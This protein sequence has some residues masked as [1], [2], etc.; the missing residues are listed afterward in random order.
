MAETYVKK[1]G[2]LHFNFL[3]PDSSLKSS[4]LSYDYIAWEIYNRLFL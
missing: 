1:N 2:V 4:N 3:I